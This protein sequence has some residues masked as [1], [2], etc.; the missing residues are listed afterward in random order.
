MKRAVLIIRGLVTFVGASFLVS[1]TAR[2]FD[3]TVGQSIWAGACT[4]FLLLAL[5]MAVELG[6][7][8]SWDEEDNT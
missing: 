5:T 8:F 7:R 3:C 6:N 4:L 2:V 1:T